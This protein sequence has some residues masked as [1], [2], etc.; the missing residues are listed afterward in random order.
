MSEP[1]PKPEHAC[2]DK[3]L[4][5]ECACACHVWSTP[6]PERVT[7]EDLINALNAYTSPQASHQLM[8]FGRRLIAERGRLEADNAA[9]REE[10]SARPVYLNYHDTLDRLGAPPDYF[11]CNRA[12]MLVATL[13]KERDALLGFKASV[14]EALNSGDGVYR[15]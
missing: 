11:P 1:T 7:E 5:Y 15:P 8:D 3:R 6:K 13:R 4:G 12:T 14:D 10:V 9:L 2:C